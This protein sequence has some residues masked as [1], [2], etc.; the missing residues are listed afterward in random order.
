MILKKFFGVADVPQPQEPPA[1]T[2]APPPSQPKKSL[3][4]LRAEAEQVVLSNGYSLSPEIMVEALDVL[5]THETASTMQGGSWT[6]RTN[7]TL[8]GIVARYLPETIKAFAKAPS[9]QKS[10]EVVEALAHMKET[11]NRVIDAANTQN[12]IELD[13][14]L[15]FL[16]RQLG[17][18]IA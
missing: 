6:A 16:T 10:Q 1:H 17:E 9:A 14:Q 15:N 18:P 12:E 7:Y 8:E 3:E 4:V 5:A 2:P 11:L 13:L